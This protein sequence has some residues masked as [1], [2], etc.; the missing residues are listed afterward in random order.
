MYDGLKPLNMLD[1]LR[2]SKGISFSLAVVFAAVGQGLGIPTSLMP[3]S[4]REA[5]LL[6]HSIVT[7]QAD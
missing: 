4:N 5:L 2:T 3:I 7:A 1:V 6:C